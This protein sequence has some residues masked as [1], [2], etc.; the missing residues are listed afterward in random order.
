MKIEKII[1]QSAFII[2]PIA[3][4]SLFF[5]EWRF[6]FS[7][8]IGGSV[9]C[10]SLRMIM[11]EVDK[12]INKPMGQTIIVG[13]S[14]VKILIIFILLVILADFKLLNILGLMIGFT[15]VQLIILKEALV[16]VK[17]SR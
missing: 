9:F 4:I 15:L 6:A 10:G 7:L 13:M 12:F 11:W 14:A 2:F 1:K 3:I 5:I 17:N 8:L 16:S